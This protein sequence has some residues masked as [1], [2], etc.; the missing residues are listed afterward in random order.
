MLQKFMFCDFC[1]PATREKEYYYPFHLHLHAEEAACNL[2]C[3]LMSTKCDFALYIG[4]IYALAWL[5]VVT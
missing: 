2:G 1:V 5:A 3:F 4:Q